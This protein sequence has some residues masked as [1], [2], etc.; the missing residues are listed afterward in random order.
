M[1]IKKT[2]LLALGSWIFSACSPTVSLQ[3]PDKPLEINLNVKID[4]QISVK[5]DKQLDDVMSKKKD[6]F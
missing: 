4:H 2:L 3:A 6:I 1:N 5:V